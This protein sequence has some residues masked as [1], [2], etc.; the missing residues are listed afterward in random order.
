[1]RGAQLIPAACRWTQRLL[2]PL[3]ALLAWAVAWAAYL[4]SMR[5]MGLPAPWALLLALMVALTAGMAGTTPWRRVFIAAGFPVSLLAVGAVGDVPAWAWLLPMALLRALLSELYA[6]EAYA[7]TL[8]FTRTKR[9]ADRVAAY[10]QAGGIESAAIHGDKNQSQRE[11]ALQAFRA[12]KLRALVATDITAR[13]IDVDNVT[14]VLNF[15]LPNVPEAYVHRIGRTARAGKSGISITLCADDERKLLKDIERTTRQRIPSFDRRKD[16]ALKLLDEAIL[17]SGQT[18]KPTTPDRLPEHDKSQKKNPKKAG[19]ARHSDPDAEFVHKRSR[20]RSGSGAR[21][22]AGRGDR[23]PRTERP[24]RYDPMAAERPAAS[25]AAK[26]FKPRGDRP[27]YAGDRPAHNG[28][29]PV[30]GDRPAHAGERPAH[31][32]ERRPHDDARA[33]KR[34]FGKPGGNGGGFKGGFKGPKSGFK[35]KRPAI[36][37]SEAVNR[38]EGAQFKRRKKG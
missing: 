32:G 36:E 37:S 21:N 17:A 27:A 34:K 12:G 9:S 29:R 5:G 6:D 13:G 20:N 35:G 14:H 25:A 3:P 18:E 11:R 1:M 19:T 2:W 10:L 31:S 38:S 28:D 15:E 7:R 22:G 23:A 4:G 8:V 26:P 16:L 33:P 30:R 24:E